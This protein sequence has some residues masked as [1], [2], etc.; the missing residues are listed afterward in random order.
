MNYQKQID[1]TKDIILLKNPNAQIEG[2]GSNNITMGI[3]YKI[4][5]HKNRLFRP[6]INSL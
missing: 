1:A 3:W 4:P 5:K 6:L 2:V